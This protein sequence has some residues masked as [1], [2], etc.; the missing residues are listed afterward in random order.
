MSA[1]VASVPQEADINGSTRSTPTG[2]R[3]TGT[4]NGSKSAKRNRS[5]NIGEE[6]KDDGTKDSESVQNRGRSKVSKSG[7][8]T[9]ID[10][11]QRAFE[12]TAKDQGA[13][14]IKPGEGHVDENIT[15]SESDDEETKAAD[16]EQRKKMR[17]EGEKNQRYRDRTVRPPP[18]EFLHLYTEVYP[19]IRNW[20]TGDQN[21]Q[22]HERMENLNRKLRE[23]NKS[24][25]RDEDTH[26]FPYRMISE[27]ITG[28][29]VIL[30][31]IREMQDGPQRTEE[32][33][34]MSSGHVMFSEQLGSQGIDLKMLTPKHIREEL[35]QIFSMPELEEQRKVLNDILHRPTIKQRAILEPALD[36]LS[37]Y[38]DFLEKKNFEGMDKIVEELIDINKRLRESNLN[39]GLKEDDHILPVDHLRVINE[40]VDEENIDHLQEGKEEVIRTSSK[41]M[42]ASLQCFG[43]S[44]A[45]IPEK[46]TGGDALPE[47]ELRQ[48]QQ[49]VSDFEGPA[50]RESADA[51]A[52]AEGTNR[53]EGERSLQN[54]DQ[55]RGQQA[56]GGS[57]TKLMSLPE[58]KPLIEPRIEEGITDCG[59]VLSVTKAG[60]GHRVFTNIGTDIVPV[61]K[62]FPGSSFAKSVR[63]TLFEK[64]PSAPQPLGMKDHHIEILDTIV[65]PVKNGN[66]TWVVY[67]W[68]AEPDP[69]PRIMSH[70]DLARRLGRRPALKQEKN[71]LD[72]RKKRLGILRSMKESPGT[73]IAEGVPPFE[74]CPPYMTDGLDDDDDNDA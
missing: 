28:S 32:A 25:G 33:K 8:Y 29:R 21:E 64:F 41:R 49:H 40:V 34:K 35:D 67:N 26:L 54:A 2:P 69:R 23:R 56:A 65:Y 19:T 3:S 6:P 12:K 50:L 31:R 38:Y 18:D 45:S 17:E 47:G 9:S 72:A 10:N 61:Y 51:N 71:G 55:R 63:S 11:A 43:V 1:T 53:Q 73:A 58:T 48:M 30:N 5:N 59:K 46:Y 16:E 74:E 39:E 24:A 60:Y 37:S 68:T 7:M 22:H 15:D 62:M 20:W 14:I 4:T 42:K 52:D 36:L 70:T 44:D 13:E 57:S 66:Y 27:Y